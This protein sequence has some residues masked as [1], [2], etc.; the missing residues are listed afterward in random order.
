MFVPLFSRLFL[1]AFPLGVLALSGCR[2]S[3]IKTY[4]APKDAELVE[5][6]PA[7]APA[8]PAKELPSLGFETPSN[9]QKLPADKMNAVQ[10]TGTTPQGTVNINITPLESMAGRE[11]MLVGMWRGVF[12]LPE[13][14]EE[15]ATKALSPIEI[16]G[17]PA[18]MFE[19]MGT[20]EGQPLRILTAFLHREGKSW[21]FKL[22]GPPDAVESQ[23]PIFAT[24]LKSVKFKSP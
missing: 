22:Q 21:F 5:A 11:V 18:Q 1:L 3:E 4:L 13:L 19:V 24:F 7:P 17:A 2:R 8:P 14:S 15:E 6:A 23:K 20:R 9:W 12:N 10:F 16:A